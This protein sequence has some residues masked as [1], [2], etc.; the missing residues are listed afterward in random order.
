MCERVFAQFINNLL[1]SREQAANLITVR[2]AL[3]NFRERK[4]DA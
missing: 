3:R 1:S 2:F 4:S